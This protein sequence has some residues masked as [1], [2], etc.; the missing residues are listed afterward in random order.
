MRVA[1]A[2]LV[3]VIFSFAGDVIAQATPVAAPAS[4]SAF[5][6]SGTGGIDF[7]LTI[8]TGQTLASATMEFSDPDNPTA[9][10]V[11]TVTNVSGAN[12]TGV[13][14]PS[15]PVS[16]TAGASVTIT[17]SGTVNVSATP[18]NYDYT[19]DFEDDEGT[20]NTDTVVV[21]IIV[22]DSNPFSSQGTDA[23]AGDGSVGN[24]Y[25]PS[26]QVVGT[27]PVL[28]L[29]EV[30]DLNT[31]L[32]LTITSVTPGGSNPTTG[33]GFTIDDNN[34]GVGATMIITATANAALNS[35][36]IGTYDFAVD[37]SDSINSTIV[38]L[39]IVVVAAN[40]NPVLGAP[41]GMVDIA[42]GGADP[43]FTGTATVG[44]DLA[45]TFQ[46]T[47]ANGGDTLTVTVTRTG[48]SLAT[49]AAAGFTGTFPATSAGTSPE[50]V[51]LAGTAAAAGNIVFTI[52][53]D[54]GNGGTDSYAIDI[55]INTPA[56]AN[57]VL[58]APSGTVDISVGGTD[59]N[60]TG[61][62][63]VG[64]N[65]A[66]TFQATDANGGDTLTVTVTRTGGS[67]ATPAA[68]GFTGT[69]PATS[70][71][72]SPEAVTLAGTAAAAGTITF[73][74]TVDDGNS[75]TDTY[76]ITL[77]ISAVGTPTISVTGTLTAFSSTGVGVPSTQQSYQVS[78]SNLTAN[79][80]VTPPASFQISLTSGSGFAGTP[81][82]LTQT[83]GTVANT[84]IFVRYNPATAG[85]HT[86]NI[87]HTSTG[88][89]TQNQPVSGS[90]AGPA[91]VGLSAFGNPG[92]ENVSPGSTNTALGFRL[93]ETGGGSSFT[94]TSVSVD[95]NVSGPAAGV[96]AGVI[97]SVALRRGG[98][99]ATVTNG[100]A[101][102][103]LAGSVITVNF[104]GLSSVV[105]AGST[106]DFSVSI[107]FAGTAVPSPNP[108]YITSI[109]PADVNGGTGVTGGAFN[110]G[111]LTLVDEL[112][113]DPFDD[114]KK[115]DSCQ[116]AT[117]GGPAWPLVGLGAL[118]LFAAFRR[119][120][121]RES[122]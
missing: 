3:A 9:T 98:V 38:N 93:T 68:A 21:R 65:L 20:P 122:I 14:S 87:T 83:G 71:G 6:A 112:P 53:V 77:T 111:T 27:T 116:L 29:A 114:D 60:F 59:P 109:T 1:T 19:V 35:N 54:D 30:D 86:G 7:E 82:V 56:N 2:F 63:T 55:T 107:S 24:P 97:T 99:L 13:T 36:D 57:P 12:P 49:P 28:D 5:T 80:T 8:G 117:R 73:S 118:V 84:T 62:A 4:G 64:D 69:F 95:I 16:G 15:T 89:T 94:V 18:G 39:R 74:V 41:S 100:G 11:V 103:S 26:S 42:V 85:P 96:A 25:R 32:T 104:T 46:A 92:D 108:R 79:I 102:W 101:G 37:V 67:L 88:A 61:T 106:G 44:D 45:I 10:Q 17:W 76:N 110:G 52:D 119:R 75:G 31:T 78:G 51:T 58:G 48:G 115:E 47:D 43:A 90:I 33:S 23:V 70:V 121:K 72:T 50:A 91:A 113:D 105:N 40:V 81:I 22:V 66:I 120:E 34:P